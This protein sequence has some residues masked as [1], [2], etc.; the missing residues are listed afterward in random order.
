MLT[1]LALNTSWTLVFMIVDFQSLWPV[2][3]PN[4]LASVGYG[5]GLGLSWKRQHRLGT[6]TFAISGIFNLTVAGLFFGLAGGAWLYLVLMPALGALFLRKRDRLEV[7]LIIGG[8]TILFGIVGL[9]AGEVPEAIANSTLRPVLFFGSAVTAGLGAA[10]LAFYYRNRAEQAERRSRWLLLNIL[11]EPI[12]KRLKEEEYPIADRISD[13]SVIFGD[14][15]SS[16]E[17][18]DE[19]PPED[20]VRLLD[21]IFSAFDDIVEDLGL[22][23]IKT[24][25][26]AYIAVSGLDHQ[27]DHPE[28]AAAAALKMRDETHRHHAADGEPLRMRFGIH[29]GPVVA[30]VIGKRKFSYDLW[31]DTMNTASRMESTGVV[32]SIQVSEA[33]RERVEDRFSLEP[34]GEIEVK[35]KGSLKTY[36]LSEQR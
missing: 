20:W 32:D 23:K 9:M 33:F 11:P 18:A 31:G 5:A 25:G 13:V 6:W 15:A 34:R 26:D 30:G 10:V 21:R 17:L 19:L 1:A 12:A 8:G 29:I 27:D 14:I 16:T 2:I 36:L 22:E 7:I 24:T 28:R 35:G 3:I 4:L